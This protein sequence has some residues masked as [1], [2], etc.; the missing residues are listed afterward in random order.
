MKRTTLLVFLLLLFFLLVGTSLAVEV[1]VFGPVQ[2]TRERGQPRFFRTNF[3]AN[4][5]GATLLIRNGDVEG[6]HRMRAA[7]GWINQRPVLRPP[8]VSHHSYEM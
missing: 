5:G 2:M 3:R 6:D 4:K 1:T 7:W 8:D